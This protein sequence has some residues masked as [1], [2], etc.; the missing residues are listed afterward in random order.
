MGKKRTSEPTDIHV[1]HRVRQ[2]RMLLNMSQTD[3]GEAVGVTFQ[4]IQ[5]YEKGANRI[6]ASR[7]QQISQALGKP[8]QWFYDGQQAEGGKLKLNSDD[9]LAELGATREGVDFACAFNKITDHTIRR[10]IVGLVQSIAA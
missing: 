9:P 10:R 4:Q 6:G 1:G 8:V 7:L 5:K 2:A 3:L